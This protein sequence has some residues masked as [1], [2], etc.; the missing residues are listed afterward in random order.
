[1][2]SDALDFSPFSK[3]QRFSFTSLLSFVWEEPLDLE[4]KRNRIKF[5]SRAGRTNGRGRKWKAL[6]VTD[7]LSPRL[8]S[9]AYFEK[10]RCLMEMGMEHAPP[11]ASPFSSLSSL[12]LYPSACSSSSF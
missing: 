4:K 5:D 11:E 8:L 9:N 10:P 3:T 1:M 7:C 2:T 12:L 6:E